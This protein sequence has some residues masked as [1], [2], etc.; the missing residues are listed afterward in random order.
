MSGD[1]VSGLRQNRNWRLLWFG[2]A[3]SLTGDMVFYVTVLLWIATIIARGKSWASAAASG[4]LIATAVPVLVIGPLAGVW[5][6]RWDRRR[7]ML[8]ADAARTV[9]IICLVGLPL[10][11]HRIPV[12]AQLGIVYSVLAVASC[13]AEFFDPSRLAILGAIVPP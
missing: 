6:D 2:Q 8:T 7:T 10:L 5:V 11:S 13:F 1:L 9:L 4:A 3:V 12:D